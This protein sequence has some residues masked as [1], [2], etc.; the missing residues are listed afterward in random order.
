[1]NVPRNG[2]RIRLLAMPQDP[3]P[4]PPGTLG[5]VRTATQHG[6]GPDAWLQID[7]EWDNGRNLMLTTPPDRFEAVGE[8]WPPST[9]TQTAHK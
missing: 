3:D 5:T 8:E 4:L 7:V 9:A 1:M 2:D 6:S